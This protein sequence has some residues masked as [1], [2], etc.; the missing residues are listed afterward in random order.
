M[1][2]SRML[3]QYSVASSSFTSTCETLAQKH[4]DLFIDDQL[5]IFPSYAKSR[6]TK[7]FNFHHKR[8]RFL[9]KQNEIVRAIYTK[10][11]HLEEQV[12]YVLHCTNIVWISSP[13]N[14]VPAASIAPNVSGTILALAPA[15]GTARMRNVVYVSGRSVIE[16]F[17]TVSPTWLAIGTVSKQSAQGIGTVA[18]NI[19]SMNGVLS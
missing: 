3:L 13:S 4:R 7:I 8:K 9:A 19:S 11:E 10:S 1:C 2:G 6:R 14:G 17:D 5:A 18:W 15:V 16:Q 12:K